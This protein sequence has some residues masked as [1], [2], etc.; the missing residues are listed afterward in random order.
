MRAEAVADTVFYH[1]ENKITGVNWFSCFF[2]IC[3][4]LQLCVARIKDQI[5]GSRW[6]PSGWQTPAVSM[7]TRR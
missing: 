7:K 6:L 3:T 2:T 5:R 1:F 4:L